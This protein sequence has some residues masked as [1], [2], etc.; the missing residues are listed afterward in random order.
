MFSVVYSLSFGQYGE[1][2]VI[3]KSFNHPDSVVFKVV[4]IKVKEITSDKIPNTRSGIDMKWIAPEGFKF[5][6]VKYDFINKTDEE[7][8]VFVY[9]LKLYDSFSNE[10][11]EVKYSTLRTKNGELNL[12]PGK[13]KSVTVYYLYPD[14]GEKPQVKCLDQIFKI[15]K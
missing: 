14:E 5:L 2:D 13:D 7:R 8:Q 10:S 12:K 1:E 6:I 4:S 3:N 11:F 15:L 9:Y